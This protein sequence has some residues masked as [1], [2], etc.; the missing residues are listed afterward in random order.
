MFAV[1][2]NGFQGVCKTQRHLDMVIALYTYPKFKRVSTDE[3][4][5]RWIRENA[6]SF[7]SNKC[8]QYGN[9]ASAGFLNV[10]YRI[11]DTRIEYSVDTNVVG[12]VNTYNKNKDV[13]IRSGINNF[14]V[15]IENVVLDDEKITSHII[16]IKRI[17]NVIG[18]YV[19][20][21]IVVPDM[22][23][24]LAVTKYRGN[25]YIIQSLQ[26]DIDNRLGGISF[27]VGG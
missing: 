20:V 25:N 21:N 22:S 3:E 11:V 5:V 9:T 27:T 26:R 18:D 6:R 17:L 4:A 1:V 10:R 19:D 7:H 23:V 8:I 2:A 15:I 16:A 14:D 12:F 13:V 24:Y